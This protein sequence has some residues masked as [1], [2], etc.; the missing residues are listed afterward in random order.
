[1]SLELATWTEMLPILRE[2]FAIWSAGLS[3]EHYRHYVWRQI[4]HPW[5]RM[6]QRYLVYRENDAIVSCCR[7]YK[8]V[9]TS[10][11]E[12]LPFFGV[13]S[14]FTPERYRQKGY[15]RRMLT[16]VIALA[17]SQEQAG[18]LLYS[19]I[20]GQWYSDLGFEPFSAIDFYIDLEQLRLN[21]MTLANSKSAKLESFT[22]QHEN[23][24][25]IR[26]DAGL[27][28][29]LLSK[30]AR[31]Y[32]RWLRRQPFGLR[33]DEEYFAFKFGREEFLIKYSALNWPKKTI[34][35]LPESETEFGYAISEQSET[36]LRI[37][38]II[39]SA[40]GRQ[41]I[42]HAIFRF[43]LESGL[44]F[45]RGWEAVIRDFAPSF[46]LRQ[47]CASEDKDRLSRNALQIYSTE[48][49]WGLPMLLPLQE[50]LTD[51]W[52]YYPC[53]FLELDHF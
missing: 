39:G 2:S 5:S 10:R 30:L 35:V 48:R 15:G 16:E 14:V 18:V 32:G 45:M 1:M 9:F 24:S 26:L 4:N 28:N 21:G 33:R 20:G 43:A 51:W 25:V 19:E 46:S 47:L 44:A 7:V 31:H 36:S 40:T 37:L 22:A 17:E 42:W 29:D 34:W 8:Y 23:E 13:G 52:T 41:A 3:E 12:A 27:P 38:E 6:H 50:R 49:T 53:P 11:G